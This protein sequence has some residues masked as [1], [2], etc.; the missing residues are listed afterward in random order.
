MLNRSN[1]SSRLTRLALLGAFVAAVVTATGAAFQQVHA[2]QTSCIDYVCTDNSQCRRVSCDVCS[3][4][5]FRCGKLPPVE[6]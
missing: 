5:D 3:G 1:S 6:Q 2:S 4:V